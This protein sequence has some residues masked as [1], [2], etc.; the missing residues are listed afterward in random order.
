MEDGV[1]VGML[2]KLAHGV[3][4]R[5]VEKAP[6][7]VYAEGLAALPKGEIGAG[8]VWGSKPVDLIAPVR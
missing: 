3:D 1:V 5:R 4:E 7:V 6:A 2:I 8:E